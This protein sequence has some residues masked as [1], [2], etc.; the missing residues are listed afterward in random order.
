MSTV[1]RIRV[2]SAVNKL[3]G[4]IDEIR[5]EQKAISETDPESHLGPL[6]AEKIGELEN[7]RLRLLFAVAFDD[8]ELTVEPSRSGDLANAD[9]NIYRDG[10]LL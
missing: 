9:G 1:D 5:E 4:A 8:F 10:E 6:L 7:L 2:R 3:S